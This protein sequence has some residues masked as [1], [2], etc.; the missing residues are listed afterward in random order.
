MVLTPVDMVNLQQIIE[1]I[2]VQAHACHTMPR[3][4]AKQ[5]RTKH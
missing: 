4:R 3:G 2:Q 1:E 5:A